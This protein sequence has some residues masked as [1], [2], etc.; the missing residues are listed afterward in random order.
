MPRY[1]LMLDPV[2]L[3][4]VVRLAVWLVLAVSVAAKAECKRTKYQDLDL[5]YLFVPLTI[6]ISGAFNPAAAA[7]FFIVLVKQVTAQ[8]KEPRAY[9]ILLHLANEVSVR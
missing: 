8:L 4:L 7:F 9:S 2:W 1:L 5:R 6:M 3:W